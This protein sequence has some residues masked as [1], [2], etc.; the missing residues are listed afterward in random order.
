MG[1]VCLCD[2]GAQGSTRWSPLSGTRMPSTYSPTHMPPSPPA[3]SRT[4]HAACHLALLSFVCVREDKLAASGLLKASMDPIGG[5][6][7]RPFAQVG[8][9][10][11]EGR[12]VEGEKEVERWR[13]RR[14]E[15]EGGRQGG[16]E[17]GEGGGEGGSPPMS[18]SC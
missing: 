3:S 2:V 12:Q 1:D 17:G 14:G 8:R 5:A 18:C 11:K 13:D 15:T 7:E 10:A 4:A 16:Q 9:Q 6:A